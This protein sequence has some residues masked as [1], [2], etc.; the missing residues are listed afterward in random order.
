MS[1]GFWGKMEEIKD[2]FLNLKKLSKNLK[3]I[4]KEHTKLN[5]KSTSEIKLSEILKRDIWWDSEEC[6]RYGLVDK[7]DG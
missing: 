1:S 6:L 3:K 7:I 2:E 4:Y 5:N